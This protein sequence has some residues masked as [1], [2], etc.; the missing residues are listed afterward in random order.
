MPGYTKPQVGRRHNA[1]ERLVGMSERA[2][3]ISIS[4]GAVGQGRAAELV[5]LSSDRKTRLLERADKTR[6]ARPWR[7]AFW[8]GGWK[9]VEGNSS[10]AAP[11]SS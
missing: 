9:S 5:G 1:G 10:S 6:Q 2:S 11:T 3:G 4:R 8:E 7:S